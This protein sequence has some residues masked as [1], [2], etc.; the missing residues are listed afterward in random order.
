MITR[1]D[2]DITEVLRSILTDLN[3]I[4]LYKVNP[5]VRHATELPED[6][7][8]LNRYIRH[9]RQAGITHTP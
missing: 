6:R 3:E 8:G 1:T 7:D 4:N 5:V 2:I 9:S